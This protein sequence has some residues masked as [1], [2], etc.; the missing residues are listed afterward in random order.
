MFEI[1]RE[2]GNIMNEDQAHEFALVYAQSSFSQ[3][4]TNSE[5]FSIT[6]AEKKSE[7]NVAFFLKSYKLAYDKFNDSFKATEE[8]ID[9]FLENFK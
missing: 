8:E 7:K 9:A 1:I 6:M 2:E 5:G 4:R 3:L